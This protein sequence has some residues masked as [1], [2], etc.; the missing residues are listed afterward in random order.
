MAELEKKTLESK[1]ISPKSKERKSAVERNN[2]FIAQYRQKLDQINPQL[3]EADVSNQVNVAL[4]DPVYGQ[5]TAT[6]LT[7]GNNI[8]NTWIKARNAENAKKA[9]ELDQERWLKQMQDADEDRALRRDELAEAKKRYLPAA[10]VVTD[11]F[12]SN[13]DKNILD[14]MNKSLSKGKIFDNE[15]EY[16][17]G[18]DAQAKAIAARQEFLDSRR[19][20]MNITG[21]Q[22]DKIGATEGMTRE[23]AI[24]KYGTQ[25]HDR[26]WFPKWMGGTTEFED[27]VSKL[28]EKNYGDPRFNRMTPL[29][30][31]NRFQST[32]NERGAN[33]IRAL[34]G[35]LVKEGNKI[36][37]I[38]GGVRPEDPVYIRIGGQAYILEPNTMSLKDVTL[39]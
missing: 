17:K 19:R 28:F 39:R 31:I 35:N 16:Q 26:S 5:A 10:G 4:R 11:D 13:E 30:F 9:N 24:D 38:V 20:N 7:M 37:E 25:R 15:I 22:L 18:L 2:E 14:T 27:S 29:Q 8:L 36:D 34:I 32:G 1:T 6:G 33:K 23:Q 3:P 21:E 12:L